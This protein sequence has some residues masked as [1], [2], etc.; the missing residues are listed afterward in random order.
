MDPVQMQN[1]S[2][3]PGV[4][5]VNVEAQQSPIAINGVTANLLTYNG[6]FPAPTIR[7][8]KGDL[9][10]LNFTNS[11]PMSGYNILGHD[12]QMTNLHTHGFHVSPVGNSDNVMIDFLPGE[13]FTYEYNL[14]MQ[15]GGSLNFYHPHVHGTVA[16]QFWAGLCGALVVEDETDVLA[17]YETHLLILKDIALNGSEPTSYSSIMDYMMGKEGNTI[18]VNGKVNPVLNIRPGQVQR[19]RI[20]NAST[21][22][23]YNLSLQNHSMYVVGAD[24]GLLDKPYRVSSM[25]LSPGERLDVLVKGTQS[26]GNYKFLSLPYSRHGNMSSAQI[27]LMTLSYKGSKSR[28]GIPQTVDPS[29]VRVPVPANPIVRTMTLSMGQGRGYINGISFEGMQVYQ[30]HSGLDTYEV[31]EVTNASGMDH[32]F[33]QHVNPCQVLSVTG[34]D[35]GYAS[36]YSSVPAWKDVVLVPKWGTARLLLPVKDYGGLAMFHCHILEHEDIGMMAMWH[37]MGMGMPM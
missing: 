37:R 19:W 30:I 2:T 6:S 27:T 34:G 28:D 4:V 3:T 31:W 1:L 14:D 26:S 18:M 15:P 24:D 17:G 33:H 10:R 16:E 29:A 25:V 36:F 9:L 32:P 7:V 22:R 11:L 23:F 35:S 12:R 13:S 20:L 21:A 5:E 8:R